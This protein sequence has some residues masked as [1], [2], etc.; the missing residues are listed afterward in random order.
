MNHLE[1][2]MKSILILCL[3]CLS[4]TIFGQLH[5]SYLSEDIMNSTGGP[6]R[7]KNELLLTGDG[8]FTMIQKSYS[9]QDD[10]KKLLLV[11]S[12]SSSG[13]WTVVGKILRLDF[14]P[15]NISSDKKFDTYFIRR[16]GL[17]RTTLKN[18]GVTTKYKASG[19][20]LDFSY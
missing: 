8:R 13:R 6:I 2:N 11:D 12:S 9:Y 18:I 19:S 7:G 4:S 14:H 3:V 16:R 5:S 15:E 1:F 10:S 20:I 17:T